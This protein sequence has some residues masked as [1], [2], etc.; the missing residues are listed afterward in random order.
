VSRSVIDPAERDSIGAAHDA[1]RAAA[2]QA[3]VVVRAL[4]STD[5][6]T[7]A[8]QL[9]VAIWSHDAV[10]GMAPEMIRALTHSG[11]CALGAFDGDRLV[12]STV[13]FLGQHE[14]VHL[15]SHILGVDR[16]KRHRSIGYALKLEQRAWALERGIDTVQWTTDPLVRRNAYFNLMKLAARITGYDVNFYGVQPDAINAGDD[17]DRIVLAWDLS[18][19]AT[20]L[21]C[22]QAPARLDATAL[23][24]AGAA[25]ALDAD[26][27][28]EPR[29]GET[30]NDGRT[31]LVFVPDDAVSMRRN[32]PVRA[33]RWRR[34][35][36]GVLMR[37]LGAGRTVAGITHDGY[38]VVEGP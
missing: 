12:G 18:A 31:A 3:G 13:G 16:A 25:T 32:D 11:N 17:S 10:A 22:T 38:Y 29:I 4:A 21:A 15:H 9:F 30:P 33:R 2:E 23:R 6:A 34:A 20:V 28:G 27:H 1:A 36:R 8:S 24:A 35:L 26:D 14:R 19:P 7:A 37:E 5:E